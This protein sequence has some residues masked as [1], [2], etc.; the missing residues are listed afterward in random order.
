MSADVLDRFC[1][2]HGWTGPA[3]ELMVKLCTDLLHAAETRAPVDVR[4]LASFRGAT[5]RIADQPHAGHLALEGDRLVISV[6]ANDSEERRRFTVCHE[7]CHTFFPGFRQG[8]LRTDPEVERF[9]RGDPEEYLCDLGAS[10]LL[11]PRADFLAQLPETFDIDDVLR[12]APRFQ[13]S[14]EATA[15]R[16]VNLSPGPAAALVID[17]AEDGAPV[18]RSSMTKGFSRLARWVPVPPESPL[19]GALTH[20]QMNYIGEVGV[21]PGRHTVSARRLPYERA[22]E[23]VERAIAILRPAS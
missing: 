6:R 9:D 1:D 23:R 13:A 22:G 20:E 21:L 7:V 15:F 4:L 18:V 8:R 16:C 10:E 3:E 2:R 11:L 19:V 12:L 14:L 17:R 5:V